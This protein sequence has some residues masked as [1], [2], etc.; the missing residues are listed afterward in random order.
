MKIT[1][2]P[3]SVE[4]LEDKISKQV[5]IINYFIDVLYFNIINYYKQGIKVRKLKEAKVE[6]NELQPEI[7]LLLEFKSKLSIVKGLPA[8]DGQKKKQKQNKKKTP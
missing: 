8:D 1:S 7:D 3:I 4:E 2:S 5:I 6:K